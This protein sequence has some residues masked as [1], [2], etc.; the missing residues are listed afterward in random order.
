M[1]ISGLL[2]F[3]LSFTL[4]PVFAQDEVYVNTDNLV[5]RDRPEKDYFVFAILHAPCP[6]KVEPYELG[7]RNNKAV[8]DKFYQVSISWDDKK[9][10]HHYVGGWVKKKYVVSSRAAVTAKVTDSGSAIAASVVK[11]IKFMGL[12]E[13]DPNPPNAAQFQPPR[14]KGGE[15]W[16]KP[17][18]RVYHSGPKGGCYY[19]GKNGHR[20]YVDKTFCR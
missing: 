11:L 9:G 5:L 10:I 2:L 16:Q 15:I 14:Y 13:D 1:K 6:L 3:L 17:A 12:R 4:H 7:Y 8:T 18:K 19:I 20:I